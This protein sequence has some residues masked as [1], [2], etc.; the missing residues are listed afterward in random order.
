MDYVGLQA[1]V[2]NWAARSDSLT[3]AEVPNF[4]AFATD[5]FNHGI[6]ERTIAPIRTREMMSNPP[7]VLTPVAGVATL[8]AD[9]LQPI[10]A[11]SLNS[12]R[13]P[14]SFI[15]NGY[16]DARYA[17]RAGGLPNS[18]AILGNS[19]STYPVSSTDVELIYY[20]KIPQLSNDAPT[21]WLIEKLPALYLH[22]S[23]YQLALFTKDNELIQRSTAMMIAMIDGLNV[24]D[25]LSVYSRASVKMQ[26]VTP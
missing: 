22:A 17:D 19:L 23:L 2:T 14:L 13:R 8:P 21:N 20:Q 12:I 5:S 9:F 7:A 3:V 24:T 11:T 16:T 18:Y 6:P 15:T 26:M 10:E 25:M 1:S 4:I